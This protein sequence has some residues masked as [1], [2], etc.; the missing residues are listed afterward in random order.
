M[1]LFK[2]CVSFCVGGFLIRKIMKASV[3]LDDYPCARNIEVN[4][5]IT[6]ILLPVDGYG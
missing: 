5:E 6:D 4:D 1:Q 3:K 2:L